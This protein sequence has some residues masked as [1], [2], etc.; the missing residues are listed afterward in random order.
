MLQIKREHNIPFSWSGLL[1]TDISLQSSIFVK[2]E[3]R[4]VDA[5]QVSESFG[6]EPLVRRSLLPAVMT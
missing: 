1:Y 5:D 3:L 4:L 2:V 6:S